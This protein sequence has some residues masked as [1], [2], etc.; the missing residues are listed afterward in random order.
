LKLIRLLELDP[1]LGL[2]V[3]VARIER[4]RN[5]LVTAVASFEPGTWAVP[6]ELGDRGGIGVLMLEGLVARELVLAGTT[7]AELIGEG[8][9]LQPRPP[10]RDDSFVHCYVQ[11]HVLAPVRVALLDDDVARRLG[12]WPQVMGAILERAIRRT[13]R[14]AVHQAL[15]QLSPVETRLLV[16]FWHLA[17]RWGRVTPNGVA[18]GLRLSHEMLG[19]LVGCQRASVTTALARICAS[20]RLSRRD[21]GTWLLHGSPPSEL[22]QLHWQERR[23]HTSAPRRR[24]RD[25]LAAS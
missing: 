1:E 18:V 21:D 10:A 16:L 13:H 17:E 8:D 23:P 12:D 11:W 25:Q 19:H 4:A 3:P 22:T 2:R 9:L 5:E 20:G 15:L 24:R 6:T 14:M 7:A